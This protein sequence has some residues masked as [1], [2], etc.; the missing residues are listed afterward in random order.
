MKYK[1]SL[2]TLLIA[3]LIILSAG[4]KRVEIQETTKNQKVPQDFLLYATLWQQKSAEYRACCYQAFN[5]AQKNLDEQLT[6]IEADKK[7]AVVVD[8]DETMLDNS[9]FEGK[10]I[11]DQKPYSSGFWKEWSDRAIAQPVPGALEFCKYV[12]ASGAEIF[13]I[14]NRKIQE[15]ESTLKNLIRLGFPFADMDHIFLQSNEKSKKSRRN[16]LA[17]N[18]QIVLL[19][20]DNLNDFSEIFEDRSENFGYNQVD[21]LKSEFGSKFIILP[22]PMYGNWTSPLYKA[23][24]NDTTLSKIEVLYKNLV[25]FE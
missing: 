22:N 2:A 17:Q 13:Y 23:Y 24:S 15:Q 16:T 21:K 5:L 25:S 8:I 11:I 10:S 4:C 1:N 18:H 3:S 12:E 6:S 19:I 9:P 20:G 14:S 7:A